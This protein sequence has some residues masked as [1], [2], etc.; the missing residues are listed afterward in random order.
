MQSVRIL[1]V[2]PSSVGKSTFLN[3]FCHEDASGS[4]EFQRTLTVNTDILEYSYKNRNYAIEFVELG[5]NPEYEN[6]YPF[7]YRDCDGVIAMFDASSSSS[8][9]SAFV[10]EVLS[11]VASA[12]ASSTSASRDSRK[13]LSDFDFESQDQS[14]GFLP[15]SSLSSEPMHA[16]SSSSH[17]QTN[18][19]LGSSTRRRVGASALSSKPP[20]KVPRGIAAPLHEGNDAASHQNRAKK[21]LL[22]L[23]VYVIANKADLISS[24]RS[25]SKLSL[26]NAT[27]LPWCNIPVG[28]D[29]RF[30]VEVVIPPI[31]Q[32]MTQKST[33][34]QFIQLFNS[35]CPCATRKRGFRFTIECPVGTA[36]S[37]SR[38][39]P[40]TSLNE[41]IE[42]ILDNCY[43]GA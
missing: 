9:G 18:E 10:S 19:M 39:F 24:N 20:S 40:M 3:G 6:V 26:Q 38:M 35:L 15:A 36:S 27:L 1:L 33:L 8:H 12:L 28:S 5:S 32:S 41:F 42:R 21:L 43:G 34:N 16:S 17:A 7:F 14:D 2:G 22:E 37:T 25:M 11:K 30:K 31:E 4:S 29:T 23:P 13:H